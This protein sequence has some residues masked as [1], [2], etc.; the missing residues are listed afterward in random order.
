M[1]SIITE[2]APSE[3][4]ADEV[5]SPVPES[6][7]A[8]DGDG[9]DTPP[10]QAVS[11]RVRPVLVYVNPS[12]VR[13]EVNVRKKPKVSREFVASVKRRGVLVPMLGYYDAE[14]EV[15]I[16]DGQRRILAAQRAGLDEA[17]ALVWPSREALDTNQVER[18]RIIDQVTAN[19]NRENLSEADEADAIQQLAL[20]GLEAT[21]IAKELAVP[22]AR[23]NA[24]ITVA[25]SD[26]ARKVV[27]KQQITLD[28]A[29]VI[30]EFEGDKDAVATLLHSAEYDPD[31]FAHQ[32][33]RLRD[34]RERAEALRAEV[35]SYTVQ[36]IPLVEAPPRYDNRTANAYL[37]ELQ[38]EDGSK[39]T[40]ENYTGKP[41]YAICI[42]PGYGNPEVGHVVTEWRSH[43]LRRITHG[44]AVQ[45]KLTESEK[46]ARRE[47]V[48][49]NKE[50]DS[51]EK[52][53]REWLTTLLSRKTLPKDADQFVAYMA[54]E[55]ATDF[56][57]S[58][59]NGT[60]A[61]LL[62]MEPKYR[63]LATYLAGN[64]SKARQVMFALA[65]AAGELALDRSSWRRPSEV[66]KVFLNWLTSWGYTTSRVEDIIANPAK[67][68]A[69]P[70]RRAKKAAPEVEA[71]TEV[72]TEAE[73]DAQVEADAGP[74]VE[75]TGEPEA[76]TEAESAPEVEGDAPTPEAEVEADVEFE[77]DAA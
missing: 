70:S 67:P 17:P 75:T 64:P 9:P 4:E 50:W 36:G 11:E 74:E 59:T 47:V 10:E 71:L 43:G 31:R 76:S 22:A 18:D 69:T 51:A 26:F 38:F 68:K 60:A 29:A 57:R 54:T 48:A 7:P 42:V 21:V 12:T 30:A 19:S 14:G 46:A 45:G 3:V 72:S 32:A 15:V 41:G 53:R 5:T 73:A 56:G 61:T 34:K 35:E 27:E 23:V 33:Q 55:R 13:L 77:A 8:P 40:V 1:N 58:L 28:Q 49:N 62:G 39:V 65:V 6:V 37:H 25:G 63:A 20:T 24:A 2:V 16:R 44:G 52:V 66:D